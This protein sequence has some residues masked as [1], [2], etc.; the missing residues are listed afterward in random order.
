MLRVAL[1]GFVFL[2]VDPAFDLFF[3][4]NPEHRTFDQWNQVRP[5]QRIKLAVLGGMNEAHKKRNPVCL[6]FYASA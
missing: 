2:V 6:A 4:N 1:R 5:V 3:R